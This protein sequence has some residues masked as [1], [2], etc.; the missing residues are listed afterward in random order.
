M[1]ITEK[2]NIYL[3]LNLSVQ[4]VCVSGCG[5]RDWSLSW[6]KFRNFAGNLP[7]ALLLVNTLCGNDF[8]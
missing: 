8:R 2:Y 1:N 4:T 3:I 7:W 6:E 5:L